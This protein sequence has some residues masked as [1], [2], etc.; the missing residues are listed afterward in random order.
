MRRSLDLTEN[1]D[2]EQV[3]I[4]SPPEQIGKQ[5]V[6]HHL[7]YFLSAYFGV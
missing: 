1:E 3:P 6:S 5:G 4:R 2:W 7:W